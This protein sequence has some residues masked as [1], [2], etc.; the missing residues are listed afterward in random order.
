MTGQIAG[1]SPARRRPR[2]LPPPSGTVAVAVV[3]RMPTG[4]QPYLRLMRLQGPIGTWLFVL[5]GWWALSLAAEGLPDLG[6]VV[7]FGVAALLMRGSACAVNDVVDRKFDAQ[8]T[9][10]ASRPVA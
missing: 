6:D 2:F 1:A 5:P 8:V 7:L 10:T 4:V 3:S 9:R